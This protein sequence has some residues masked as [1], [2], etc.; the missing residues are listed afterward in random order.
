MARQWELL[1]QIPSVGAGRST[2][3]L[4]ENLRE[5]GFRVSKRQ[6]ERDLNDLMEAFPIENVAERGPFRWRWIAGASANLPGLALAEALSLHLIEETLRP[7][8]P[9]SVIR[10]VEPRFR[11]ARQ[12]L[13]ARQDLSL[14]R[15]AEKV[16]SI[17]PMLP[18]LP[19]QIDS[20]VLENVQ[21]A[22]LEN[23]Q[24]EVSYTRMASGAPRAMTLHPLGLVQ[25]GPSTYLVATAFDYQ[26]VRLYALHRMVDA[27]PLAEATAPS[28]A[29]TL[30]G[31]IAEGGLQFVGSNQLLALELRVNGVVLRIL[32][33][34]PLESGQTIDKTGDRA[35]VKASV[36]D[37]WQLRWWLLS[38]GEGVEVL[39]PET[40]REEIRGSLLRAL[41]QYR[42]EEAP[43][44][45]PGAQ[46]PL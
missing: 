34:T 22:L 44:D 41:E 46:E 37:S 2:T 4:T 30:D 18:M 19:P 32:E 16:R 11:Q 9:N 8:L 7:L 14:A 28:E 10:A 26:D 15:W 27:V 35:V 33:E 29:F 5:S 38:L 12:H 36:V 25:R 43:S 23:R 21:M 31:Y 3:Q 17:P 6:V 39:Q 24:L 40:L 1:R 13:A 42:P 45:R 20:T